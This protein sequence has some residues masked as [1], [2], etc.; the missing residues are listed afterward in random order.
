MTLWLFA[1]LQRHCAPFNSA[2]DDFTT[3]CTIDDASPS[4]SPYRLATTA[5]GCASADLTVTMPWEWWLLGGDGREKE[6][7]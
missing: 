6:R 4:R 3:V 2:G 5:Q 7:R 1:R